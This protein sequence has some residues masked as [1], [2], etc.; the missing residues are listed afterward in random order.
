MS[1]PFGSGLRSK[2]G[3]LSSKRPGL[4]FRHKKIRERNGR[5]L[6]LDALESRVTPVA[7]S[8]AAGAYLVDM[9]QP[10]QTV[11]NALKP[12]GLIYDM[13]TNYKVP[14][15]WAIDP[16]KTT[17]RLDAGNTIPVDFSATTTTGTKNY[18]GGSFIIDGAFLTPSVIAA[19]NSWKAQ[20]VVVDTLAAP[21]TTEI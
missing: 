1:F 10:T 12:Y 15:N 14:I 11:G 17:F 3:W 13:V 6:C 9:G 8:F 16:A 21:L 7:G 4:P 18:A 5:R 20:G 19:I 2:Q